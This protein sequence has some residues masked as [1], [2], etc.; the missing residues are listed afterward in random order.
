MNALNPIKHQA[1]WNEYQTWTWQQQAEWALANPRSDCLRR[2]YIEEQRE[3]KR[4][5]RIAAELVDA[6]L[7]AL[8]KDVML[9]VLNGSFHR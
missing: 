7:R 9:E 2:A 8:V 5:R 4:E 6:R 1:V 3:Y